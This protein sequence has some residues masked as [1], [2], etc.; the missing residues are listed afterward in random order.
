MSTSRPGSLT[1]GERVPGT[2]W[3]GCW[4]ELRAGL[5]AMQQ[6]KITCSCWESNSGCKAR[7]RSPY[8]LSYPGSL[9]KILLGLAIKERWNLSRMGEVRRAHANTGLV[10][11]SVGERQF[12][13]PIL[14]GQERNELEWWEL[15]RT[16][17]PLYF[18]HW[19][20]FLPLLE[21]SN[22]TR[23]NN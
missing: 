21:H 13:M 3:I 6:R 12:G 9:H 16:P 14:R 18:L 11:K 22:K 23:P 2:H 8:G 5:D 15:N 19:T 7:N 4:L 1:P 20:S 17:A 10:G